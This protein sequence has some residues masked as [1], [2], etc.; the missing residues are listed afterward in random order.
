M[1]AGG[2]VVLDT[3]VASLSLKSRLPARAQTVLVGR[4][5]WRKAL[6]A[7]RLPALRRGV[8]PGRQE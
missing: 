8:G 4:T 7:R 6:A 2:Y 1:I 3:D 5:R